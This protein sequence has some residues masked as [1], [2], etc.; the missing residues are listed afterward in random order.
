MSRLRF[1]DPSGSLRYSLRR[2]AVRSCRSGHRLGNASTRSQT[3]KSSPIKPSENGYTVS[4]T[5]DKQNIQKLFNE[6][7]GAKKTAG[8]NTSK[9]TLEGFQKVISKQLTTIQKK[10]GANEVKFRVQAKGGKITL[11]AGRNKE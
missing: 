5:G 7:V 9:L 10:S 6:Y 3:N 2:F 11:K 4:S 1:L 8:E